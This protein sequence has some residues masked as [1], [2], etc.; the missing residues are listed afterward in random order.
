MLLL[1][2]AGISG[3]SLVC[4]QWLPSMQWLPAIPAKYCESLQFETLAGGWRRPG[5]KGTFFCMATIELC[6]C[7]KQH[8]SG[9]P[10]QLLHKFQ[11]LIVPQRDL[12]LNCGARM[13]STNITIFYLLLLL[14]RE[15]PVQGPGHLVLHLEK[16]DVLF[17]FILHSTPPHSSDFQFIQFKVNFHLSNLFPFSIQCKFPPLQLHIYFHF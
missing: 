15:S 13:K 9:C 7:S 11:N 2:A 6:I 16:D 17:H 4:Q 3:K 8:I 14:W 10:K 12:K 1:D 5:Q